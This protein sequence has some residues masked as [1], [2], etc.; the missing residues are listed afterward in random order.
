MNSFALNR[1]LSPA[2]IEPFRWASLE[3]R[4]A[5]IQYAGWS[6][7]RIATRRHSQIFRRTRREQEF[8]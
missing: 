6:H 1:G 5:L 2:R 4:Y 8:L 7:P 3:T